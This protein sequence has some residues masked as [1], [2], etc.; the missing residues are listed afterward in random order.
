MVV[1]HFFFLFFFY[2]AFI[3]II[4]INKLCVYFFYCFLLPSFW[5]DPLFCKFYL[6]FSIHFFF[7]FHVLSMRVLLNFCPILVFLSNSTLKTRSIYI[8]YIKVHIFLLTI[9]ARS[10]RVI[11]LYFK[12]IFFESFWNPFPISKQEELIEKS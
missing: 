5:I 9:I 4:P 12:W 11:P 6:P 2:L 10:S 8:V 3:Q 7:F 1:L